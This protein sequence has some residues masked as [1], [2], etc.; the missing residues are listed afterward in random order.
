MNGMPLNKLA[1][2]FYIEFGPTEY[3]QGPDSPTFFRGK[4]IYTFSSLQ[5]NDILY[6]AS[7][8]LREKIC[9]EQK[10]DNKKR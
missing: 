2:N 3:C 4:K 5:G 6:A 9:R 10:S 7:T 1:E 8:K